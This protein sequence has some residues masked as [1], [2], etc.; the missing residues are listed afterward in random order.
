MAEDLAW[1]GAEALEW[2]GVEEE[3]SGKTQSNLIRYLADRFQVNV[4]E[5]ELLVLAIS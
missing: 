1:V 3:D 2:A 5:H 4:L